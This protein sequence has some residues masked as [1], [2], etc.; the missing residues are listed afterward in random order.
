MNELRPTLLKNIIGQSRVVECL[1]ISIQAAKQKNKALPHVLLYGP[2]GLG[3]T[4]IATAIANEMGADI[5]IANGGGCRQPKFILPYITKSSANSILFI[6][7]IHRISSEVEELLYPVMEDFRLDLSGEEYSESIDLEEFTIIGA[8]TDSGQLSSPF[9]D[10]FAIKHS[11][12]TYAEKDIATILRINSNKFA[13][14]CD[15]QA[16]Q[17][18]ARRSRGTPRVANNLLSW[19]KDFSLA[20]NISQINSSTIKTSMNLIGIDDRGLNEQ[21]RRYL[22]T[23][24]RTGK[25]VGLSTLV[26]SL[27]IARETV[28]EQIEPFL[29]QQN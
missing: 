2:P 29:L 3:K 9:R 18:I 26:S 21:D 14:D 16:I 17:D 23:L 28:T 24:R 25:P 8:T 5:Q 1:Q 4:T 19:V 15:E 12:E 20:K 13:L 10:R 7:E 22:D 6:D 27:N 11:L